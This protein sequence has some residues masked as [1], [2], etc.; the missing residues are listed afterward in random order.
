[1]DR[2]T[3]LTS[4]LGGALIGL[5]AA[6][7]LLFNGRIAGI[8]GIL[9]GVVGPAGEEHGRSW[10]L[11]FIAGLLLGGLLLRGLGASAKTPVAPLALV[12]V[13]GVL[14]GFGTR[15]GNGCTSGHGVCG[16]GRLSKRS[17]VAT[18]VFMASAMATVF[19]TR[20]L[21]GSGS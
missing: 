10:R 5:S 16:I 21:L 19:L 12:A 13:G 9:G 8:S 3:P 4:T 7:L 15:W 17:M 1:M 18:C 2:F 11:F 6:A 20:H 14:V